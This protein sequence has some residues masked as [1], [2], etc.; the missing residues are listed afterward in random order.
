VRFAI[1]EIFRCLCKTKYTLIII[2]PSIA[3]TYFETTLRD[4]SRQKYWLISKCISNM[5]VVKKG[6]GPREDKQGCKNCFLNYDIILKCWRQCAIH[7][8]HPYVH[9]FVTFQLKKETKLMTKTPFQ[10]LWLSYM[11]P[12][13]IM[14]LN[15]L[16]P[17]VFKQMVLL[18]EYSF[19]IEVNFTLARWDIMQ[20]LLASEITFTFSNDTWRTVQNVVNIKV[21]IC[22]HSNTPRTHACQTYRYVL[23]QTFFCKGWRR[24]FYSYSV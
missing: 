10:Q 23:H 15:Q 5:S 22:M 19:A 1:C 16:I 2:I 17:R 12:L 18:E 8:F 6:Q 20:H 24:F 11:T 13:T 4:A 9:V 21:I 14:A 3:R 7:K